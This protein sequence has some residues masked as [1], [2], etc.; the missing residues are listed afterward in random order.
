MARFPR[1]EFPAQ[2]LAASFAQLS[3]D[4]RILRRQPILQFIQSFDGREYVHRNF[5]IVL[6]QA[7]SVSI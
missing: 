4:L 7:T 5:D 2:I 1:F 3:N 6:G